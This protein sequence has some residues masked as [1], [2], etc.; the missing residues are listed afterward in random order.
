MKKILVIAMIAFVV[1]LLALGVCYYIVSRNADG[2]TFD[3]VADIPYNKVGILLA[4]S[5]YT[6]EGERNTHFDNRIDAADT[7]FKA[8]MIDYIIASGG[9]YRSSQADGYDEPA[10]IRDSLTARGIPA[11]RIIADYDG[12]RTISSIRSAK[13]KF[14]LDSVTLIS[15]QYH[16]ERAIYLADALGV[17]AI[18][19]NAAP[20]PIPSKRL[21]NTLR[22]YFARVKMFLDL[23]LTR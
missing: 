14:H 1:V 17:N 21:R 12:R 10:A 18:G 7:L 6:A 5:P 16:T 20:S 13:E 23:A 4:T 15:Q 19:Y 3:N 8:H 22:E 9:D 11:D 2:R